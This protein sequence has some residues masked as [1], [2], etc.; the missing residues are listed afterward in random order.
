[1]LAYKHALPRLECLSLPQADATTTTSSHKKSKSGLEGPKIICD[2]L[3]DGAPIVSVDSPNI[4]EGGGS[5]DSNRARTETQDS[6]HSH[7]NNYGPEK[8]EFVAETSKD[9]DNESVDSNEDR[10]FYDIRSIMYDGG[11]APEEYR[12]LLH[13]LLVALYVRQGH[14]AE[15]SLEC[16]LNLLNQTSFFEPDFRSLPPSGF[17]SMLDLTIEAICDRCRISLTNIYIHVDL[18][19]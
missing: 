10:N 18:I 7:P 14:I 9:D 11:I 19:L 4:S 5:A 2:S 1:M 13:P 17:T 6:V 16:L 12:K 15:F 8:S 3:G